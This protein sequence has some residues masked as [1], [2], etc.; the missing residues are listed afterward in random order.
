MLPQTFFDFFSCLFFFVGA[1][2]VTVIVVPYSLLALPF[3][4]IIFLQLRKYYLATCRQVKR[5]EAVYRSPVYSNIPST[6]DGLSIIRAFGMSDSFSENFFH[7]QNEHTRI[8]IC[9]YSCVRWL[10]LR[11]DLLVT[12]F[13][14][15]LCFGCVFLRDFLN[16]D[17]GLVGLLLSYLMALCDMLQWCVRQSTE[18]ENMMVST[19]R[20][21]EYSKLTPE[22]PSETDVKPPSEW[23]SHGHVKIE[24]LNLTYPAFGDAVAKQVLKSIN[25]E[26][27]AGKKIGIVGRTGAGKSSFLQAL[28]RIVEPSPHGCIVID[29]INTSDLGL[30][31]LRSNISIIPQ[32][33]FCFKGTIRFNLDP[34]GSYPDNDLW[35]ALETVGL[36]VTMQSDP[37][38]L[39]A[40]VAE[41]GCTKY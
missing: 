28:F 15:I 12:L 30:K 36:G 27:E 7:L 3:L 32:E 20:I 35:N 25:L 14:T 13:L 8:V 33:P 5:F 22:A 34:F 18:A 41:N 11:L 37:D 4:F 10:G 19:E 38:K 24:N 21:I 39:D 40:H 16:L 29:G 2:T 9:F 6:L 31:D 23:P 26:F 1:V 17:P